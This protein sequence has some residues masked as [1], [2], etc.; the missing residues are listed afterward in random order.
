MMT[1]SNRILICAALAIGLAIVGCEKSDDT[2]P[3]GGTAATPSAAPSTPAPATPTETAATPTTPTTPAT[4]PAD[5]TAAA[6]AANTDA[7]TTAPASA[8]VTQAQ[9]LLDQTVKYM[10]ENKMDLADKT[11]K[12]LEALKPKLPPEYQ[13]KVD[14]A[15]TAFNAARAGQGN[16][17][18]LLPGA[19]K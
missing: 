8:E 3:S 5:P 17:D 4:T 16:L 12:Q 14:S 18:S 15:R 9:T 6:T 11:L 7:P 10:K 1:T 2:A 13:S 19:A